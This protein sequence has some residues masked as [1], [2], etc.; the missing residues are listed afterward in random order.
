ML[1]ITAGLSVPMDN[2]ASRSP[3]PEALA[4]RTSRSAPKVILRWNPAQSVNLP[5][6]VLARLLA[7]QHHA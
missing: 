1:E 2:S 6:E 3:A 7:Q 5:A 4:A